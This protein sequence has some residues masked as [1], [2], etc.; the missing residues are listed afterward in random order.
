MEDEGLCLVLAPVSRG[1]VV[2]PGSEYAESE[3]VHVRYID[4]TV[5]SEP[6][7]VVLRPPRMALG[8]E[9]EAFG[10]LRGRSCGVEGRLD[11]GSE[12]IFVKEEQGSEYGVVKDGR[13][14]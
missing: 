1:R 13:A 10:E 8:R 11:V 14:E 6:A 5:E 3:V 4:S 9:F 2:V 12:L 7:L